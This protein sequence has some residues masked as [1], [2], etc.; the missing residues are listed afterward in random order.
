MILDRLGRFVK[1]PGC[2]GCHE[3]TKLIF[4]ALRSRQ[5]GKPA[6]RA[7]PTSLPPMFWIS[8]GDN[9]TGFVLCF[10]Y[11]RVTAA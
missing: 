9:A 4:V 3:I 2:P 8:T 10:Q 5:S 7:G 1:L 11:A 6:N